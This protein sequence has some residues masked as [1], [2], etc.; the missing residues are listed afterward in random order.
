MSDID[1]CRYRAFIS[2]SHADERWA[3]WLHRGLESYRVPKR[4]VGRKTRMGT[5]PE[6]VAPVFR[7]REELASSTDLGSDLREALAQSATQIVICSRA[8]AKSHWVNEEILAYKRLGRSHRIFCLIVDGE[9]YASNVPGSEGDECFP[10]ALHFLMGDD[11]EL[12]RTPAEPIAADARPGKD[13]R[14]H[15]K[16]KLLAGLL[17]VGFDALRQ[18]EAQR[19]QRRLAAAAALS[20]VGMIVAIGLATTAILARNE[21]ERQRVRA[22]NEAETA[23][24]TSSF[25]VSLFEVSDPGESRGRTITAREILTAGAARIDRELDDQ[26]EVQTRLM[27]T[28]GRVYT[29][30][31]LYSDA[32]EL[33]D[34]A[35]TRRRRLAG[36]SAVELSR[37]LSSLG[38]VKTRTAEFEEAEALYSESITQLQEQGAVDSPEMGDALAGLA[39]VYY[40]LGRYDEAEPVLQIGRAH[41]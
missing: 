14:A 12:T 39:E 29:S 10:P 32:R 27:T 19:R 40:Y 36:I 24:E 25:L 26:P 28:I 5:V 20:T 37:S 31:G 6:R 8:S 35:L 21:A 7:D 23:R 1:G 2:Y 13:G 3:R 34:Q 15:A 33:L 38:F 22:E 30:L 4:L 18:R 16:L 9:P 17:G 41:V 11:G